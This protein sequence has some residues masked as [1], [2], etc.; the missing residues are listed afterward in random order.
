MTQP[1]HVNPATPGWWVRTNRIGTNTSEYGFSVSATGARD[2]V[3]GASG[4]YGWA[5]TMVGVKTAP[6][7]SAVGAPFTGGA[8]PFTGSYTAVSGADV[9]VAVVA[10]F[11]GSA[12]TLSMTYG[13]NAMTQVGTVSLNNDSLKGKAAIFRRAGGGTGSSLTISVTT[14]GGFNCVACAISYTAVGSVSAAQTVYGNTGSPSQS[15]TNTSGGLILS[16]IGNQGFQTM[17]APTG[18]TSRAFGS[19]S[20]TSLS[21]RDALATT[22]FGATLPTGDPWGGVAVILSG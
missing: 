3:G 16:A 2:Y 9:F 22:T 4:A 7:F 5:G 14:G 1:G 17:S 11:D 12:P 13:G 21:V 18:G 8:S 20:L 6:V 10:Q 19:N 15:V